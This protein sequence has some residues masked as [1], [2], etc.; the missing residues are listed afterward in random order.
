MTR[1]FSIIA[2]VA[3]LGCAPKEPANPSPR[4]AGAPSDGALCG[5]QSGAACSAGQ[6]C[7]Y[8]KV[9]TCGQG[10]TVGRCIPQPKACTREY[11]PVCGCDG[12]TFANLCVAHSHA[13][14]AK[15]SG[16][17]GQSQSPNAS[18]AAGA[19][20]AAGA[21]AKAGATCGLSGMPACGP[22]MFCKRPASETCATDQA[23]KCIPRPRTCTKEY[24]PLCGCDGRSY[25]N[26]C[27]AD[28][29]GISI[30]KQGLCSATPTPNK[31]CVRGGCSGEL[32]VE[33]GTESATACQWKPQ[34]ICYRQAICERQPTGRCEWKNDKQL[35]EC[36]ADPPLIN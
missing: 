32:C 20:G 29:H 22:A 6:F 16:D 35:K 2:L 34:Y 4:S 11:N 13:V 23:G 8:S 5:G 28:S 9:G 10:A 25:S 30:R 7:D 27:V 24:A 18:G 19:A 33:K 21:T 3:C 15:H 31:P 1:A 12:R 17:C 36:L 14:S 26:Q